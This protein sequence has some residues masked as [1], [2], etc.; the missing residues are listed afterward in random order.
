MQM[1]TVNVSKK[2]SSGLLGPG[3][4]SSE[5]LQCK[6]VSIGDYI[7][8]LDWQQ[9]TWAVPSILRAGL[10]HLPGVRK[11]LCKPAIA[12]ITATGKSSFAAW[13]ILM[14]AANTVGQH[15]ACAYYKHVHLVG[16]FT[17]SNR[18]HKLQATNN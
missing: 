4:C 14:C 6:A 2:V 16:S 7:R 5:V 13:R 1:G 10:Q 3:E 18:F 9:Q 11:L 8:A 15:Q 12:V 17:S